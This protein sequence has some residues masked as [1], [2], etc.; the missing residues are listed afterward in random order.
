ML[1]LAGIRP[2]EFYHGTAF[3]GIHE[4]PPRSYLHGMRGRMDERYDLMRS[5]RDKRYVYIRN[6]NPHKI[7]GQHVTY[8]WNLPSAPVWE[9]LYKEGRLKAPQTLFWETKP[10]EELYDLQTD[11]SEVNNLAAS[12][13]HQATLARFRKAHR[14]YELE[15]RDVGLLPE[16]EMQ[17]RAANSTPYEMGHDPGKFPVERILAAADLASS[18]RPNVTK[19]L[20]SAMRDPDSG[21]RYWGVMGVLIRGQQE[22]NRTRDAL[23]KAMADPS[24]SVR[25]AA[26]E[27]LGRYGDEKNVSDALA[28]LIDLADSE[29]NNSYIA[30]QALNAIDALGKKAAPLKEKIASL[31]TFDPKSPA[32]ANNDAAANLVK[33]LGT[34][35]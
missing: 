3:A 17:A 1:S 33:W 29:K 28:L 19:Q 34:T 31:T 15:V 18:G 6:Y 8:G 22:V 5:T 12:K 24:P 9:R 4:A 14:D 13:A 27:A 35:L 26:A 32:R 20:E 2:P 30:I 11:P 21:V 25:I 10:A 7:Y 23:G 16:A